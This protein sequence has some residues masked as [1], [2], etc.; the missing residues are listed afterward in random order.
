MLS[1]ANAYSIDDVKA[2][3][4]R[5]ARVLGTEPGDL[6]CVVEEK[7]DGLAL[8]LTYEN[9]VLVRGTTRGDGE[10]GE[11][12]SDNVRTVSE[13]PLRLRAPLKGA[14]DVVEVR[15]ELYMDHAGFRSLNASLEAAEQKV[16][17]N[18]RNAAAGSLRLL[19]SKTTASRPLR[20]FA[21]QIVGTRLNQDDT[22][23]T[24]ANVGFRVNPQHKLVHSLAEIETLVAKYEAQRREGHQGYDIDGLVIKV[25]DRRLVEDLGTIANSPRSAVAFKLSPLEALTTIESIEIQVG[26]TGALTP[27]AHLKPVFVSGVMVSRATL[28]NEEQIRVKDVRAGDTVWVRRAGD[29]IPEI[30]RVDVEK[31]AKSSRAYEMPTACPVCKTPT[32]RSKSSIYCPNPDCPAKR[33]ERMIHFCS[34]GA[35]DIRGLGDQLVRRLYELGF[36]KGIPDIY[37]LKS[38]R[39]ELVEIEGLGEKSI[40]KI[41]EAVETSKAQTPARFLYAL[42]IDLIGEKTA[43]DLVQGAGSVD[44]LFAMDEA[45]LEELHQV[46]PETVATIRRAAEGETLRRELKELKALGLK[47]PFAEMAVRAPVDGPLKGLSFVITGTLSQPRDHFRDVIRAAGGS[48]SDSVSKNTDYLLAGEKAGSKMKKAE[49]LGVKV[50]GEKDLAGLLKN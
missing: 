20:F 16:F 31:R 12:V 2:F 40:D 15:G 23:K 37:R 4:D 17:A 28:H 3:F 26:R 43:D 14:P 25:N 10:T 6:A 34:R 11:D 36:L 5:A 35:M 45:A 48:V 30:V 21:Y 38:R 46:G 44:R 1:L 39:S 19:D 29:V 42:G 22:L 49:S 9:G 50:I 27:V 7:M 33:V 47:A 13:I 18:P 32:E 24:L 41:L 8:S